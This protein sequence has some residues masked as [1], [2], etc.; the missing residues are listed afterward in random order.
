MGMA[1]PERGIFEH[2][3]RALDVAH[4]EVLHVGDDPWLDVDGAARAG[5]RTCWV[6]R[7]GAAWPAELPPPDLEVATLDALLAALEPDG[8]LSAARQATPG[9]PVKLG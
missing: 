4:A 7:H 5:L 9:E 2:T 6:N 1:K 8:R 3:V